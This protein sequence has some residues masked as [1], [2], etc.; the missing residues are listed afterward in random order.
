MSEFSDSY[1]LLAS[2]IKDAK[3]LIRQSERY[4][5]VIPSSG[6]YIPFIVEGL[7]EAGGPID[8]LV[9][10]NT[11]LLIH[12]AYA[13]DY[14]CWVKF[15]DKD[16]ELACLCYQAGDN[17]LFKKLAVPLNNLV[18]RAIINESTASSL[19]D[20]A[21]DLVVKEI[22]SKIAGVLGLQ[23]VSWLSCTDLTYQSKKELQKKFSGAEFVN[24]S[25]Q[26][27]IEAPAQ[28]IP[29]E[30]CSEP[31]Q[32]SFMYLPVP[33]VL[34]TV[35]Q[36]AMVN[37]HFQYWTKFGDY[38]NET[39]QGFWM[40]ELYRMYLPSRYRYL[41]NRLM[42]LLYTQPTKLLE[43]LRAIIKL[44]DTDLNWEEYLRGF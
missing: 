8:Q 16:I 11:Q 38:D 35:E 42:N 36:E 10:H 14:G 18:S 9:Q 22:G 43:T 31:D 24:V 21:T 1:H 4:G 7:K 37:R 40:Y 19:Q 33:S 2:N 28:C 13:G 6:K 41:C 39:Q 23:H 17:L 15:F 34:L 32:P 25:K 5:M 27:Q 26:G 20:L 29:N 3:S 12:Y 44:I 30:W